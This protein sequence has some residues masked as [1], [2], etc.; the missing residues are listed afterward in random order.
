MPHRQYRDLVVIGASAGGA[1]TMGELVSRL[2]VELP[3]T[4][5]VAQHCSPSSPALLADIL[6]RAGPL[7]ATTA[8]HGEAIERGHIY[9]APPDHHLLVGE[10]CLL[11]TRGPRE[12]GHRPAVDPLFRSAARRYGRRMIAVILSGTLDDG[13]A[14]LIAVKSR[15]GIA[16]VQDPDDALHE[17]MPRNAIEGDHPDHVVPVAELPNLLCTLVQQPLQSARTNGGPVPPPA[18]APPARPPSETHKPPGRPAGITC[19][20]CGGPLFECDHD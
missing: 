14:G 10:G 15:G 5:L 18:E 3:A 17:G 19:P 6:T 7:R 8:I 16:V 2:P 13:T 1:Q 4:L 20:E 9:V 12:N 11:V